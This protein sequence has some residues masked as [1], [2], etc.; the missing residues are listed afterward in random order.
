MLI[1]FSDLGLEIKCIE[2]FVQFIVCE[3]TIFA[4]SGNE[5]SFHHIGAEGAPVNCRRSRDHI[6]DPGTF[7]E[8]DRKSVV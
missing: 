1:Q 3:F 8:L 7:E 6:F 2:H 5:G 4:R